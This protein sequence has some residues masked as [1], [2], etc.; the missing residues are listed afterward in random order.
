MSTFMRD[1]AAMLISTVVFAVIVLAGLFFVAS[2]CWN[3]EPR[4]TVSLPATSTPAPVP[5]SVTREPQATP[6]TSLVPVNPTPTVVPTSSPPP[7]P[8]PTS[9]PMPPSPTQQQAPPV[10]LMANLSGRWQIA[11]TVT[12]GAGLGQTYAFVISLSQLGDRISGGNGEIVINGL[13]E[14]QTVRASYLQPAFGYTGTFTWTLVAGNLA[15]GTFTSS[16]PN[17]GTSTLTRLP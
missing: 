5:E 3:A 11:D 2:A 10:A 13:V 7:P 9:P 17:S 6:T 4:G 15:Q 16:V 14:D 12:E 8:S 1:V